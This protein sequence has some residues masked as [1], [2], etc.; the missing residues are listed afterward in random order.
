M[1]LIK[2][3]LKKKCYKKILQLNNLNKIKPK[4]LINK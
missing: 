4:Y 3:N 1:I 2:L